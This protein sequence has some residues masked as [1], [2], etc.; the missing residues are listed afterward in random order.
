MH[1]VYYGAKASQPRLTFNTPDLGFSIF[2]DKMKRLLTAIA[3]LFIALGASDV[4]YARIPWNS[5]VT[6]IIPSAGAGTCTLPAVCI[7]DLTG[8]LSSLTLSGGTSGQTFS[9]IFVQDS[10]GGRTFTPPSNLKAGPFISALPSIPSA[11]NAWTSWVVQFD[12]V[13]YNLVGAY[14]NV[15]IFDVY[16]N[17]YMSLGT[18]VSS[19]TEQ[20]QIKTPSTISVVFPGMTLTSTCW[21]I[22]GLDPTQNPHNLPPTWQTGVHTVCIPD[23]N[24]ATCG[25]VNPTSTPRTPVGDLLNIRGLQ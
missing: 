4:S 21:C 8:N 19:N 11:T 7:F 14:D 20:L 9:L 23:I 13:N 5:T 22:P 2:K 15:P 10:N 25:I 3:S 1:R 17:T 6:T 18:A 24:S 12:G 16:T